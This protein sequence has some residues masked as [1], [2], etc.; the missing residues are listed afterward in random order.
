MRLGSRAKQQAAQLSKR[1]DRGESLVELLVALAVMAT[2]VVV[3]LGALAT[4]IRVCEF[5]RLQTQAGVFARTF[6]ETL[7]NKV[8]GS[9]DNYVPCGVGRDIVGSY[10][11]YLYKPV[12]FE[13][14]GVDVT[15][16]DP[17]AAEFQKTCP[18]TGDSGVQRVTLT[19][20]TD[21]SLKVT[22]T[23]DITLRKPCRSGDDPCA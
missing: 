19:L 4:A 10:K 13:Q 3:L 14:P 7:E 17:D 12:G 23:L 1:D 20:K 6:A 2:A 5:H 21:G 22:E 16:W 11:G 9:Q 15:F 18:A 8:T